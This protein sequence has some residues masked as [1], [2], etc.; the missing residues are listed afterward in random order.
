MP[1]VALTATAR[2]VATLLLGTLGGWVAA[3]I[4]LPLPW[5]MGPMLLV[6]ATG[7]AGVSIR[8]HGVSVPM[9]LR[10]SMV[11]V[12]GVMLGAGFTP[13]VVSG[14]GDWWITL[15]ALIAFVGIAAALV[16]QIYRRLFGFDRTT[17]FFAAVPGGLVEMAI[18]GEGAGGDGRMISLIHF[19]RILMAVLTIPFVMEAIYGPVGSRAI[20]DVASGWE[21]ELVD[22]AI[23]AACA[24]VGYFA[25]SAV[26][27]PGA[28]ISGPLVLS[29]TVHGLGLTEAAPPPVIVFAAQVVVGSALGARFAGLSIRA[30]GKA[31]GA[32]ATATLAML[33]VTMAVSLGLYHSGLVD[34]SLTALVLAYAPGG[35]TEMS[36]IALTLNAGV[37]FVATHHIARIFIAVGLMPLVWRLISTRGPNLPRR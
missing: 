12:I 17:A 18:I 10:T 23:L 2:T 16:F 6:G 31:L 19:C 26:K 20:G 33:T 4:G 5:M 30:V 27:L 7:I 13:K 11:P 28:Q 15:L 34:E 25:G 35:V 8:G 36:L 3:R 29:A 21:I 14:I 37:A 22:I 1:P 24:L 9:W 32:S